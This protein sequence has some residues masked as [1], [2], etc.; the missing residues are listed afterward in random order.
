M[1][2]H[3]NAFSMLFSTRWRLTTSDTSMSASL[4]TMGSS[5]EMMRCSLN[6]ILSRKILNRETKMKSE[7]MKTHRS[8]AIFVIWPSMMKMKRWVW[9]KTRMISMPKRSLSFSSWNTS[10]ITNSR[11][12]RD[13]SLTKQRRLLMTQLTTCWLQKSLL[14]SIQFSSPLFWTNRFLR[15]MFICRNSESSKRQL[16]EPII[17]TKWARWQRSREKRWIR[18]SQRTFR[19]GSIKSSLMVTLESYNMMISR[20]LGT[21]L[22]YLRRRWQIGKAPSDPIF[23]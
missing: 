4:E 9:D 8:I 12:Q 17:N 20:W 5:V 22:S 10:A 2:S 7:V 23:Y 13:A 3:P 14:S 19:I 15:E 21:C 18:A 11:K 6:Y 16:R 1:V